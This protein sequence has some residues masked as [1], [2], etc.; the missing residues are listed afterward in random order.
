MA[1]QLTTYERLA[2][3]SKWKGP[4]GPSEKRRLERA[5]DMVQAAID[6]HAAFRDVKIDVKAKG[7]YP[8]NTNVR[9]DSDV[10]IKVQL[11][12]CFYYD[13]KI[14]AGP[15]YTGP[16]TKDVLRNEV[17]AALDAA[18]GNV[19]SDHNIAF[20]VP[21]VPGSRPSTD[22]VPC[23]KYVLYDG[24]APDGKYEGSVVF[25]RDG[26]KIVNWPEL[27]FTNGRAKNT[28]THQRYKFVVR[29]LKNVENDLTAEGVIEALPS[30]FS[31]CLI[32]N[33]PNSV[34][35]NGDLDDAVRA[36]LAE[37]YRQL[38]SATERQLMKEPNE[39]KMLFG[40]E[41]KW[42]EQHA[43]DLILYGWRYLNYG[44]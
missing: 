18:F 43:L 39:V 11:N 33:V 4:P 40:A 17:Y 7:S 34:F 42:S 38:D 28:A 41:Q 36:C 8:N 23:F 29:V 27:Q 30:Y 20:Y 44:G 21:E 10:D 1:R 31:E 25:G 2:L 16:W 22:V 6:R 3:I 19:D 13:G 9:G 5:E 37:V 14:L 26:K 24:A 15:Y 35:L 32:Y 12:E